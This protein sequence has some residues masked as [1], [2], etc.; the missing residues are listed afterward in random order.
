MTSI[1][2]PREMMLKM[3][4]DKMNVNTTARMAKELVIEDINR[5]IKSAEKDDTMTDQEK[6]KLKKYWGKVRSEVDINY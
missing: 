6:D 1:L 5:K 2:P 4:S 3:L